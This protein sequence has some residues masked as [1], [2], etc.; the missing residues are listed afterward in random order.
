MKIQGL[1][2]RLG[3]TSYIIPDDILPNVRFLAE[4]VDDIELVL[5]EVDDGPNNLPDQR[6][7]CELKY[8]AQQHQLSYTVHLPLDLRLAGDDGEQH[9]SLAKAQKVID[10]TGE[11]NPFAYVLHLDGKEVIHETDAVSFGRWNNQA[12]LAL[13]QVT[14]WVPSSQLLCVENLE[15]YIPTLWDEVIQRGSV[16]RCVDIGHLW[17]DQLDPIDF[18]KNRLKDTRVM[19]IHGIN[20]RDHQSLSFVPTEELQRVIE[21]VIKS[22]FKGAMTMEIFSEDD[23]RSSMTVLKTICENIDLED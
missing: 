10:C 20:G 9:I 8:L 7:I 13:E 17:V 18:L 1:P 21:Y 19:H 14:K 6:T 22:N 5:F 11:L 15:H 3:T 23:F 16:S 12:L 2:F 4:L